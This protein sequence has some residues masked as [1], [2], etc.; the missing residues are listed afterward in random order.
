MMQRLCLIIFISVGLLRVN[1][2]SRWQ[3]KVKYVMEVRL[4][5]QTNILSGKQQLHYTN[6]SPDTLKQLFY[7]LYWN[8]FQ[9]N[10]MMDVRSRELGKNK[11]GNRPDWD[12]RVKDR[13]LNLQPDEIGYQKVK[14]LSIN[15]VMQPMRE[16]ETILK[17]N[18]SKPILPS[19][20]VIIDLDF[21]AQVPLQIRRSGR[22][23]AN[24]V[25]YSM[26]QWYPKI[27]EYD[28]DGWH[29][30]PYV[31]REF[32]GVWGDFQVNITIDSS[33]MIGGTGY[34]Q[35]AQQIGHGYEQQGIKVVRSSGKEFTWKFF[36]PNVHDFAWAADPQFKHLT[37]SIKNGP[38]IHIIYKH[39]QG[40]TKNDSAWQRIADAVQIVYPFIKDHFGAYPY[41]QYTFIQGGDGG[42]EYPM[43]TLINGPSLGT[44]FHEW[45]HSWYQMMLGTNES[46]YAWMDEGFTEFAT[47]MVEHYYKSVISAKAGKSYIDNKLPQYHSSNY[48]AYFDLE[49]SG[50]EEPLTTHADHF[51]S[52]YAYSLAAYSKGCVFL[53]Q[54]GY[55]IGDQ[56]RDSLLIAYY[57]K[58]RFRHPRCSDF[59]KLAEDMSKIQLDWYQEY[60]VNGTK[61]IDYAIDS[62]W[63]MDGNSF[64]R[65]KRINEMPMPIDLQLSFRDSTKENHYIPM[66]LMFGEKAAEDSIQ[67][68]VH[69]A[70]KWTDPSYIF[71]FK[72]RLTDL[73]SVEIDP[74]QRMADVNRRNN[75]L[76][77]KW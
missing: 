49:R 23:A 58:W 31:A 46:L 55:V 52:N 62:L 42:M 45:M 12:G 26:T 71:S 40:D 76:E 66:Y 19:Q 67:R 13:I 21:E 53:S 6:H 47:D 29:P 64:V 41:K 15:G 57:N 35:N 11:I 60:W 61:T 51:N 17:V 5:V 43:A 74:S 2:Q 4:N 50:L 32:Y 8:A 25:R 10:S 3:Q 73:I 77:I 56:V 37:K 14:R 20:T 22:D 68:T 63:E 28:A 9:P 34:L 7:H 72:R 38:E 65:I 69:S 30:N 16:E 48:E 39:K 59:I 70:W 44:A 36:A 1:A 54:L 27:C 75:K 24:G 33:Y 18:L